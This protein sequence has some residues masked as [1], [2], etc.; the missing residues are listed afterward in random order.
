MKLQFAIWITAAIAMVC[1]SLSA[2]AGQYGPDGSPSGRILR[3]GPCEYASYE[4]EARI[5]SIA[6]AD[7]TES[8]G[9]PCL[10]VKFAFIPDRPVAEGPF[11]ADKFY[12]LY[13]GDG[14]PPEKAFLE[15]R[16]IA[17]GSSVR[18]VM[19]VIVKG[20]CTPVLFEFPGF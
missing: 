8:G 2:V 7:A 19:K 17:V 4:G 11:R 12:T 5:V 20:T 10:V 16:G 1:S 6:P 14:S 18:G 3:G 13:R 15:E 9:R